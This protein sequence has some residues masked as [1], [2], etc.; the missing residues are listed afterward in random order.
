MVASGM[1]LLRHSNVR[2]STSESS[3]DAAGLR[4]EGTVAGV[5][6]SYLDFQ[7]RDHGQ[8]SLA[9]VSS[10]LAE[11]RFVWIDLDIDLSSPG[12][13]LGH[14][15]PPPVA[16]LPSAIEPLGTEADAVSTLAR[17]DGWLRIR[18]AGV[19]LQ[20]QA[21][22]NQPLDIVLTE[23]MLITMHRGACDVLTAV[24]QDYLQDFRTH[25]ATPSFLIYEFWNKQ[26]EQFLAVQ[27]RLEEEVE[28]MRLALRQTPDE[29]T[30]QRLGNVSERLLALRKRVLPARRVLEELVS[31][32]T[33]LVS[34]A[35]LEFLAKMIDTL[36]RLLADI[37]SNREILEAAMN[38]ALTVTSH[39]TNRTMNRLAVVSTIFL[40]LTFLCGIYGMNFEDMP[41]VEWAHGYKAFWVVSALMTMGL[42]IALRR[43]RLL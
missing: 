13:I 22:S 39:R 40:P 42:V 8:A 34:E 18:L 20:Q 36:A 21:L 24:R 3:R 27:A 11:G 28:A 6:V 31:R 30:F 4:A 15:S 10:L 33:T 26:L 14:L 43:A 41:E 25:A 12:E 37:A 29:Q 1:A 5:T 32:K 9:A 17:G 38:F 19:R 7:T 23:G 16:D 35:T 2:L